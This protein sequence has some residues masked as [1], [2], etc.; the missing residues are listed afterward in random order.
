MKRILDLAL[1]DLSQLFRDP[2]ILLFTIAIPIAFTFFMGFALRSTAQPPDPR[3]ALGWVNQ[4]PGGLISQQLYEM[5]SGSLAVRLVELDASAADKQLRSGDVAGVLLVPE[6]YSANAL[7]GQPAQ[8]TL[9]ADPLS[10]TGQSLQQ[11]LRTPIT[12]LM[13]SLEIAQI[14]AELLADKEPFASEAARQAE[15]ETTFHAA[16]QA[17]TQASRNSALLVVEKAGTEGPN[18]PLGGN[19]YNQSSPGILVQFAIFQMFTSALILIQERKTRCLQRLITTN[20]RL[21]HLIAGHWL[22]MFAMVFMQTA[23]LVIFGQLV[24][25]V[26]YL[27]SPLGTLLVAIGLCMWISS[28][29][30]LIGVIAKGEE[31]AILFSMVAMILF[32]SLGGAWVPL[33]VGSKLFNTVGHLTPAAWAMDGFQNILLRGLG[34]NSTIQPTLIL[35]GYAV[36]FFVLAVWRFRLRKD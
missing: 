22:A 20:M 25:K 30:L 14:N 1:N 19:P 24:L 15:V 35:L 21:S 29:G 33:D 13:S 18:A 17:W 34:L 31:Q 3:L 10:T 32:A 27:G 12:Q 8:L 4:D 11:V 7:A 6:G 9:L 5:M 36:L 28:M 16:V 26:N 2:K 23:I